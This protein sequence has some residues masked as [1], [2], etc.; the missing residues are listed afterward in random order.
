MNNFTNDSSAGEEMRK[1]SQHGGREKKD[2][3]KF[4]A[5]CNIFDEI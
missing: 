3:M 4:K 2:E 5:S 1:M